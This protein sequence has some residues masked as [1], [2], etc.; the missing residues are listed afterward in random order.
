MRSRPSGI[1]LR[2]AKGR[3]DE[4]GV[5]D[6]LRAS[7][8]EDRALKQPTTG[9]DRSPSVVRLNLQGDHDPRTGHGLLERGAFLRG[10]SS[11]TAWRR[12]VTHTEKGIRSGVAGPLRF[13]PKGSRPEWDAAQVP[14]GPGG[15]PQPDC[16]CGRVAAP[17]T[18]LATAVVARGPWDS[19]SP[20]GYA[21]GIVN[22]VLVPSDGRRRYGCSR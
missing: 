16:S 14:L 10:P 2:Q 3:H 12:V 15:K 7:D 11:R 20:A 18:R 21:G 4:Q 17:D 1:S 5:R 9:C 22:P 8:R 6:S 19:G 13:P